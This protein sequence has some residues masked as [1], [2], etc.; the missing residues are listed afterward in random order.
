[1]TV[2]R[3]YQNWDGMEDRELKAALKGGLK[4]DEIARLHGRSIG[5]IRYRISLLYDRDEI[6]IVPKKKG[7]RGRS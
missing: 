6:R 2:D 3:S 7:G 5:A 4:L 1:M